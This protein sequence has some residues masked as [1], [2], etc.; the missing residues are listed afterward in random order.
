MKPEY[1][2]A[3]LLFVIGAI[4]AR[5]SLA[6]PLTDE[7]GRARLLIAIHEASRSLFWLSLGGFFLA[8]G[9]TEG[10]PEVRWLGLVPI[11]MAAIRLVAASVLSRA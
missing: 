8:Y 2:L 10:A 1:L 6:E 5:R 7:Q 4:S 9:L 11:V 3:G